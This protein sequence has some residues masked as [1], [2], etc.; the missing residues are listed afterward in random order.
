MCMESTVIHLEFVNLYAVFNVLV[1]DIHMQNDAFG[2]DTKLTLNMY[3]HDHEKNTVMIMV[4]E[5]IDDY[6]EI[7]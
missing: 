2:W 3:C 4:T 7:T 6:L 1:Y 5:A